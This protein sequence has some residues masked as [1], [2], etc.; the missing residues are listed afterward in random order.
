MAESQEAVLARLDERVNNMLQLQHRMSDQQTEQSAKMSTMEN[1]MANV[2]LSL[3]TSKPVIDEFITIKT[4]V[5]GAGQF[6]KWVWIFAAS[7]V[8][9]LI[10]ARSEILAWLT[11]TS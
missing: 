9:F 8:S 4:K 7:F 3:T 2:E 6:G 5:V 10:G 11:K 1:R